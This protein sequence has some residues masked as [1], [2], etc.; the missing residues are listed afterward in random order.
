MAEPTD[1]ARCASLPADALPLLAG[2]RARP[3]LRVKQNGGLAWLFW[4]AH[5]AAVTQAVAPVHGAELFVRWD[6]VWR[7]PGRS[8]PAF[9]VPEEAGAKSLAEAVV[10]APVE[11]LTAERPAFRRVQLTLARDGRPRPASALLCP[12]DALA[13]WADGVPSSRLAPLE[14]AL[15]GGLAL[16]RGERL[17]EIAGGER[18]WGG[19]VLTPLG[20]RPEPPLPERELGRALQLGDDD[21]ALLAAD[22]A[23]VIAGGLLRPPT[24]AGLRLALREGG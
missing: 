16:V 14:A 7:R 15:C 6:G 3:G 9:G 20:W 24:R 18:F 19:A 5:D 11:P 23:E 13:R 8:L 17:P 10:P 12:L 2:L 21:L 4:P 1:E 22:G